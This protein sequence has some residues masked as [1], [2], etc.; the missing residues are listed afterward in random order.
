MQQLIERAKNIRAQTHTELGEERRKATQTKNDP[1]SVLRG[2]FFVVAMGFASLASLRFDTCDDLRFSPQR[3][4][5]AEDA[6]GQ[7]ATMSLDNQRNLKLAIHKDP[8]F[9]TVAEQVAREMNRWATSFLGREIVSD[10]QTGLDFTTKLF[11]ARGLH[12]DDRHI[13][14]A[15]GVAIAASIVDLT[16]YVVNN[17]QALRD[18]GSSVVL[19]AKSNR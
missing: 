11:R 12:L 2:S 17:H 10:W 6:L 3:G 8:L 7:I 9:L 14:D 1:H 18:A 5:N 16:L 4:I 13:R 19:C 15:D